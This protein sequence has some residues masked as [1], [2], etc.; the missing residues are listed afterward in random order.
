MDF[1]F[2]VDPTAF[3][4]VYYQSN[5]KT[6]YILDEFYMT[7][8]GNED[9]SRLLSDRIGSDYVVCDSA[10]PRTI[11]ELRRLGINAI[12]AKKG[13]DSVRYG[14][15]WLRQ[16]TI[17]VDVSCQHFK[18]E[19]QQYKWKEDKFGN[20]LPVPVDAHNHLIDAMR[21]ATED[22]MLDRRITSSRRI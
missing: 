22:L 17:I 2:S 3:I 5:K 1:G 10:E 7:D 9:L 4:D 11:N 20:A 15:E 6:L 18:N 21:Y 13:P 14:I 12:G 19:L 8:L 16:Q